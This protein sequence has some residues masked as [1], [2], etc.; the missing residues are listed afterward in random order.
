MLGV[1]AD[2]LFGLTDTPNY[3]EKSQTIADKAREIVSLAA[4]L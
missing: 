1:S 2:Y 4:N 3:T